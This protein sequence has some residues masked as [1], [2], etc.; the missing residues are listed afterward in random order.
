M[1]NHL[2]RRRSDDWYNFAFAMVFALAPLIVMFL[3]MLLAG[4]GPARLQGLDPRG[5][6]KTDEPQ[7]VICRQLKPPPPDC[8]P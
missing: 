7:D 2:L 5:A 4:C 3:L 8:K 6:S 1:R